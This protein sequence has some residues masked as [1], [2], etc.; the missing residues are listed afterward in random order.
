MTPTHDPDDVLEQPLF[1]YARDLDKHQ[2]LRLACR[3]G[4]MNEVRQALRQGA[5][6]DQKA[7]HGTAWD[8]CLASGNALAMAALLER[9]PAPEDL[10]AKTEAMDRPEIRDVLET[11]G[12]LAPVENARTWG[13][14]D[15]D[16]AISALEDYRTQHGLAEGDDRY[17]GYVPFLDHVVV[18]EDEYRIPAGVAAGMAGNDPVRTTLGSLVMASGGVVWFASET[19]PPH[20]LLSPDMARRFA[21][22]TAT[23]DP[24]TPAPAKRLRH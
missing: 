7:G 17:W 8:A 23:D 12:L 15:I 6:P 14:A 21:P 19:E 4:D 9:Y 10:P 16:A 5:H 1:R 18:W 22:R 3:H 20:L 24:A 11:H 13:L 2:R